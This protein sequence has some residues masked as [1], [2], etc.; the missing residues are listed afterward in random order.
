MNPNALQLDDFDPQSQNLL[1]GL[2]F[3]DMDKIDFDG[4]QN[5]FT[6][7]L[8]PQKPMQF[9]QYYSQEIAQNQDYKKLIH[10]K[11]L[12]VYTDQDEETMNDGELNE[13]VIYSNRFH[14]IIDGIE[15]SLFVS[16]NGA[17]LLRNFKEVIPYSNEIVL[18]LEKDDKNNLFGSVL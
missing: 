3:L 1:Q 14:K 12:N 18:F 8:R 10:N 17:R 15:I 13:I 6:N 11:G 16:K 2:Q 4:K 5:G 9:T 7:L